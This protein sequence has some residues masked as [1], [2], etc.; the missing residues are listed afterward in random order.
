MLTNRYKRLACAEIKI[1]RDERQRKVIDTN[2]ID[3]SI[4]RY[5]VLNPIIITKDGWL[6]A[7]ERRLTSSI[8]QGLPDIPVRFADEISPIESQI[9]EL[10]ENVH[11]DDL[12]WQDKVK[13]LSKI[14]TLFTEEA[15]QTGQDWTHSQTAEAVGLSQGAVS[16]QLRV[17][18]ELHQA[19]IIEA[20]TIRTAFNMLQRTQERA[21]AD[22][23]S[24]IVEAG[25]EL[26]EA[27]GVAPQ[28]QGTAPVA[29]SA[30]TILP[31]EQ[32]LL[33]VDF[34][35]WAEGYSGPKF[36]FIHCDFP[37]GIEV[38]AGKWSGRAG[39]TTYND[40]PDAY[41]ALI[42]CLGANL[43]RLMAHSGHIMFWFGKEHEAA[44]RAAFAQHLP[45]ISLQDHPLYWTKTDNVGIAP[46]P[47]RQP[48]R[49]VETAL[50][51]V[52]EDHKISKCKAN[53]YG[54][55]TDKQHHTHTKPEPMLRH[56]FEM[57]VDE[58]TRM[59]DPTA[60]GG[61][62]LR[63]AESLGAR[64]VLGLEADPAHCAT[65]RSALRGFRVLR[66]VKKPTA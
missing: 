33:N 11:R 44:T 45:S 7:G 48:R 47:D 28:T 46:D 26:D 58:H 54:C 34:L 19:R 56:F 53:W 17:G 66:G 3:A 8:K 50:I 52:R 61:S 21:M 36:N 49:V 24:T 60:G 38:F 1:A 18:T 27:V 32:S 4:K 64:L 6:I 35:N 30:P 40:S 43:D 62:A 12:I 41:W 9:L 22:V 65:A 20:P 5:G 13:A 51:G 23:M 10:L 2:S 57:F 15:E 63:A 42:R 37:Y 39:G 55:P 29:P 31:A 16:E 59:L 14:H 25:V